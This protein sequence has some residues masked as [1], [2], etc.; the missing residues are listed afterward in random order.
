VAQFRSLPNSVGAV[1]SAIEVEWPDRVDRWDAD[2]V[3]ARPIDLLAYRRRVHISGLMIRTA[4][5]AE[6]RF[7]EH[8]RGVEDR[9][10]CVRLLQ[11]TIVV[12]SSEAM[13]RVSKL[14]E[15]LSAQNAGPIYA[16]LLDKYR[17]DITADRRLHADWEY[18][19]ARAYARAGDEEEAR[20]H[21]RRA[22]RLAPGRVQRWPLWLASLGGSRATGA[23]FRLQVA[24]ASLARQARRRMRA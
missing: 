23:A 20:Q 16:Y 8:L 19:I 1:E 21:V 15:G 24:G 12:G 11:R 13:S 17:A 7:D 2:L 6:L 9:D 3:G 18:R 10:F 5:A 14:G 22:A 4:L